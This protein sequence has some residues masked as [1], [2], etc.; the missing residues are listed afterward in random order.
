MNSVSSLSKIQYANIISLIIFTIALIIEIYYHG[1]DFI[2]IINIANFALAWYMFINIRKVQG[3][4]TQISQTIHKAK[5]GELSYRLEKL[6][7]GGEMV[8]L[9]KT[10]NVFLEQLEDFADNVSNSIKQASQKKAY[11]Q[12]D[13]SRFK[14]EFHSNI[15]VTNNAIALMQSD[16]KHIA[17]TDVNEA[18]SQIGS[19]VTGELELLENDLKKSLEHIEQIVQTSQSTSDKAHSST[20][21]MQQVSKQMDSL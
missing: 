3:T 17:G 2:R 8:E 4:V 19:G 20:K 10:L 7:D 18:I 6:N 13:S 1:F 15:E 14:G 16:T 21:D 12:I 9:G 11:P 5:E